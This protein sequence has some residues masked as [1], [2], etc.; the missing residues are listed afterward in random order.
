MSKNK[1]KYNNV[2]YN[3]LNYVLSLPICCIP[4]HPT[5]LR[6]ADWLD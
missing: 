4:L 3:L 2:E 5:K 1:S 6:I